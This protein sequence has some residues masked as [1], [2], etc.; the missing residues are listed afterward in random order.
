MATQGTAVSS[1]VAAGFGVS[2]SRSQTSCRVGSAGTAGRVPSAALPRAL[3]CSRT[4]SRR[5]RSARASGPLA[6][7]AD[8]RPSTRGYQAEAAPPVKPTSTPT[9]RVASMPPAE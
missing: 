6:E 7:A 4:S 1:G 8:R 3:R 2:V 9:G 5:R